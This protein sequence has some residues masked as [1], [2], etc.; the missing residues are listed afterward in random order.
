MKKLFENNADDFFT[1]V[2]EPTPNL[3]SEEE[4]ARIN[5]AYQEIVKAQTAPV[6]PIS[7]LV[8]SH[9]HGSQIFNISNTPLTPSRTTMIGKGK[10]VDRYVKQLEGILFNNDSQLDPDGLL[11]LLMLQEMRNN[12]TKTVKIVCGNSKALT[13]MLAEGLTRFFKEH[14]SVISSMYR[15]FNDTL[16]SQVDQHDR[17][18]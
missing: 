2:E 4:Q 3:L 15:M 10:L 13:P 11:P 16:S 9:K 6:V 7:S 17:T 18:A 12:G 1:P 8:F 14:S 5:K